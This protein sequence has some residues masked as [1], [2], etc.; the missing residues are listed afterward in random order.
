MI[1]G[2]AYLDLYSEIRD[3]STEESVTKE[4]IDQ[5]AK[6]KRALDAQTNVLRIPLV[7]RLW[8]SLVIKKQMDLDWIYEK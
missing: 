1:L 7:A 5:I 3:I 4:H 6:K 8:S 2:N